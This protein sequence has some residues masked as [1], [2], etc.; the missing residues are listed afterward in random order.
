MRL[1]LHARLVSNLNRAPLAP[2][3]LMLACLAFLE[4]VKNIYQEVKTLR[5]VHCIAEVLGLESVALVF[6][7]E[8]PN[9][10]EVSLVDA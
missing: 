5:T 6:K 4:H 9:P 3:E 10:L 1:H 2:G 8:E 7:G